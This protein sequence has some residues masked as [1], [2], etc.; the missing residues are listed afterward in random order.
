[1]SAP[2]SMVMQ[3]VNGKP[4]ANVTLT[5]ITIHLIPVKR[6]SSRRQYHPAAPPV[7]VTFYD[8]STS[9]GTATLSGGTASFSTSSLTAGSHNITAVYGGTPLMPVALPI[10]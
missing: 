3:V 2:S 1:M 5:L 10:R 9:I 8:G 6:L 4:K 7:S